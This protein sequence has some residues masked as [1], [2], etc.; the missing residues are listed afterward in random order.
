MSMAAG[1]LDRRRRARAAPLGRP[2]TGPGHYLRDL[3]YG[4]LDGVV[5]TLAVA[6]GSAGAHLGTRVVLILGLANL[7]ADGISMG[8][9]NYLS[10]KSEVEQRGESVRAERPLRHG[11]A[12]LAAFVASGAVP[13]AAFLLPG[14]RLLLAGILSAL[15]LLGAGALRAR[16]LTGHGPLWYGLEMLVVGAGAAAA[17]FGV[18]AGAAAL[19]G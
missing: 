18:G 17:A 12:T 5:T 9:S 7:V 3:V 10:L 13:L 14:P 11:A 4:A 6:A 2:A 19:I 15:V 16:F 8:A 1:W